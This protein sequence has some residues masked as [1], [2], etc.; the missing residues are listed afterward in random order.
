M[1]V[2]VPALSRPVDVDTFAD[3]T[4]K[5]VTSVSWNESGG[6]DIGFAVNLST[7][8]IRMVKIRCATADDAGEQLL[9]QAWTAFQ[10]NADFLALPAPSTAQA[11][12]QV[13][14]LTRQVQAIIRLLAPVD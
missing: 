9:R 11:L 8:E 2:S 6:L 3:I 14:A 13:A 5:S 12:A 10:N 1:I 4:A 7:D